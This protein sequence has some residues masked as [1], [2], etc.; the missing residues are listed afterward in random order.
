M[1]PDFLAQSLDLVIKMLY[2]S[3]QI[4]FVNLSKLF[5]VDLVFFDI[6]IEDWTLTGNTISITLC[7]LVL[8]L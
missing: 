7:Y 5:A 6:G 4:V 8:K 1:S 3:I 2:Y